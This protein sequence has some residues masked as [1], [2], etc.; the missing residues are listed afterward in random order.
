MF[1]DPANNSYPVTPINITATFNAIQHKC[2]VATGTWKVKV[3]NG[4]VHSSLFNFTVASVNAQ[5]IGL[6]ISGSANVNQNTSGNQYTATAIM[7]DGSTPTVTPT[8]SLNSVPP[9]HFVVGTTDG[10]QRER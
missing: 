6:S 9:E 3:V 7:S 2:P 5:L 4:S 10:E 1:Y 8:W